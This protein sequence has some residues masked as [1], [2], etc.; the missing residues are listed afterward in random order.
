MTNYDPATPAT[1]SLGQEVLYA[2]RYY[3]RNRFVMLVIATVAIGLAA[4]FNWGWLV[5]A[6]IA[7][8][9]LAMAPC[10]AMCAL[11]LCMKGKAGLSADGQPNSRSSDPELNMKTP[12]RVVASPDGSISGGEHGIPAT[13]SSN[14][15]SRVAVEAN[16]PATP[17]GRKGC[18]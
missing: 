12:L 2:V 11:G 5:A 6:G 1:R 7:P 13:A 16:K 9:L 3:L 15:A 10:A 17:G 14:D 8:I 4:K 18:C